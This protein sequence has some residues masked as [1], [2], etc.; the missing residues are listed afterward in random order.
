MSTDHLAP[1]YAVSS[2]P[3]LPSPSS[4]QI[5]SSTPYSQTPSPAMHITLKFKCSRRQFSSDS[6]SECVLEGQRF[7]I[8]YDSADVFIYLF[9]FITKGFG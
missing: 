7:Q 9:F 2:I 8:P 1:R 3:P 4:V 6:V 5:F